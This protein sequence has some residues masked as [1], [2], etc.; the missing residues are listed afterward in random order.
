MELGEFRFCLSWWSPKL[1]ELP[2]CHAESTMIFEVTNVR[3]ECTV[4]FD[5]NQIFLDLVDI[6]GSP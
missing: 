2:S 6:L 5:V 3:P 1:V 4:L